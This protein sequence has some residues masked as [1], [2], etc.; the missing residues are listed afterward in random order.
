[1]N[2]PLVPS[3]KNYLGSYL[4]KL[5]Q[6]YG[7]STSWIAE[8]LGYSAS[9]IYAVESGRTIL[10]DK[11]V[12]SSWVKYL[13]NGEEDP[14]KAFKL[15][16]IAYPEML[17]RVGK[18]SI[19][20]RVR[21]LALIQEIHQRG[22]PTSIA[23]AID[24][25]ILEPNGSIVRMKS[26]GHNIPE[27]GKRPVVQQKILWEE[28]HVDP[29]GLTISDV[30]SDQGGFNNYQVKE[31]DGQLNRKRKKRRVKSMSQDRRDT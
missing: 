21:L 16:M 27:Y 1:M 3:Q 17:V 28:F 9:Y 24:T 30:G 25:S 7:R 4:K 12:L 18:L 23:D 11:K 15:G 22:L 10:R 13:S 14:T 8:K 26:N 19:D 31:S 20:D 29:D 2:S 5:R 6:D